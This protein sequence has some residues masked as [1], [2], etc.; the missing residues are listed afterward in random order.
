MQLL[1][2]LIPPRQRMWWSCAANWKRT[3]S[4]FR[5]LRDVDAS[6]GFNR[7]SGDLGSCGSY[8]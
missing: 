5:S 7:S 4:L 1:L 2:T 3:P 8:S 6:E